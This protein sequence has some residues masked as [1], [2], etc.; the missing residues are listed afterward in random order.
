[1][2]F[3][4]LKVFLYFDHVPLLIMLVGAIY[5]IIGLKKSK[6]SRND[7]SNSDEPKQMLLMGAILMLVGF[8]LLIGI[9]Y[10]LRY[11]NFLNI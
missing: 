11:V 9:L 2:S 5:V 4:N 7:G 10:L 6:R 3:E 8:G 1:M